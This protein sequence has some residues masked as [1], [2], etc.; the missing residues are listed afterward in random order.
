MKHLLVSY[1]IDYKTS[2]SSVLSYSPQ[3]TGH[4][5]IMTLTFHKV[6]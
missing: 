6:M 3:S 2:A 5:N 4:A 1:R